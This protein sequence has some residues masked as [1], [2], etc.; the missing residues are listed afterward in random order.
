MNRSVVR[1]LIRNDARLILRDPMLLMLLGMVLIVGM[2]AR[3]VLP[4]IDVALAEQGLMPAEPGGDRFSTTYPMFVAFLALWQAALMPGTVFGFLLLDEKEDR[5]LVAMQVVPVPFSQY[6]VYRVV[7]PAS[8]ALLFGLML[9]PIIGLAILPA[10][11]QVWLALCNCLTAPIVAL[12]LATVANNKVQGLALTKFGGIAGLVILI[13]WFVPTP[14]QWGL[15]LFPPFLLCKAHWLALAGDGRW[16]VAS[17]VGLAI[18]VVLV[19]LLVRWLRIVAAR[20]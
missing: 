1:Q 11:T 20:S 2:L 12:L 19:A 14:W 15:T 7:L 18:Q 17:S 9:P 3:V 10:T 4:S 5:T 8:A 16:M 13:G 6:L